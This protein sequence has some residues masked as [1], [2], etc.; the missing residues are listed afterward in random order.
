MK[1][2]LALILL[3]SC[4]LTAAQGQTVIAYGPDGATSYDTTEP[5]AR[6]LDTT[7][8][9]V[10]YRM[11]YRRQPDSDRPLEDLMLLEAGR[12]IS[13]YYSY[14]SYQADSLIRVTPSE[15]IIAGINSGNFRQGV[16]SIVFQRPAD[17]ELTYTDKIAT[18]HLLYTEPLPEFDWE[19]AAGE[20]EIIG[21][22]C[23]RAT[24][25]FRGR[26]YE[27]WYAEE[28]PAALGP[29]KFRGLPGLI[30]AVKDNAGVIELEAT[31]IVR[32]EQPIRMYERNYL[33]TDRKKFLE[34]ERK[35]RTDPVGYMQASSNVRMTVQ[36]ADGM[37]LSP[38]QLLRRFEPIETE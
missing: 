7:L 23:R 29:W 33:K 30:L 15:Q 3:L 26:R 38:D 14:R 17:G 8:F 34:T 28:I 32:Q 9:V 25:T 37:P 5:P 21:Y 2:T 12:R 13:K 10:S 35:F 11:L 16:Q 6:T 20:R 18:D 24:C 22:A 19:L 4:V 36:G 27:A 31:G 1:K